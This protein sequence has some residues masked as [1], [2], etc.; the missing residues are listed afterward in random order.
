M[1]AAALLLGI[2]RGLAGSPLTL[3]DRVV[4]HSQSGQFVVYGNRYSTGRVPPLFTLATNQSFVRLEP[5]LAAVSCERIKE[6]LLSELGAAAPW[7]G[8]IYL[9]L[10][11]ARTPADTITVTS[12]RFKDGWQYRVDFPDMVERSRYV[13]AIVQ[14]LLLE[15]A[16]RNA[17]SRACEIPLWLAEGFSELL[18]ASS[19]V[20]IILPPPH[21][22]V[23]GLSV[24]LTSV[25][26][27]K[28]SLLEQ[29]ETEL[30]GRPPL[31]FEGLSWSIPDDLSGPNAALYRGSTQLFVG[32]LLRL[33]DGRACFQA[34]LAQLPQ[35][36]NWQFAFLGAFRAYFQRPLDVEKWWA[37]SLVQVTGRSLAQDWPLD[38]SW[39]KLDQAIHASVQVRTSTNELPLHAD[40][41][42]QTI[43]REWDS[44][45]QD[46]ALNNTLRELAL[47]RLRIAQEFVGLVQDYYQTI[48]TYLQARDR[49]GSVLPF[50]RRATRRRA[51]EAAV[52]QLDALDARR[53]ALRP[54]SKPA[55][56]SPASA[57]PAPAP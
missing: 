53:Q 25:N 38:E 11:P 10:H 48:Q 17:K 43:I 27:R 37:L 33:P 52:R 21:S 56:E 32:E 34:M 29:A 40:V 18:L 54:S 35:H 22:T 20:E 19:E 9:V 12:E 26:K 8:T 31:T 57:Q 44:F 30:R 16:N 6:A 5:T 7:R 45:R 2:V 46:Q 4:A 3:S 51:T 39:Q 1:V 14:V 36:Y 55:T 49:S 42:L 13:R 24:T 47:L 23:N 15:M 28:R 41:P 50:V